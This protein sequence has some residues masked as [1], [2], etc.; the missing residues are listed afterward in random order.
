MS[1]ARDARDRVT[2]CMKRSRS[3]LEQVYA[4]AK[5]NRAYYDQHCISVSETSLFKAMEND[6]NESLVSDESQLELI[7]SI[8]KLIDVD[9]LVMQLSTAASEREPLRL[10]VES[11]RSSTSNICAV[12]NHNQLKYVHTQNSANVA[13]GA[14][15]TTAPTVESYPS[16]KDGAFGGRIL[17]QSSK[18]MVEKCTNV[19]FVLTVMFSTS[20]SDHTQPRIEFTIACPSKDHSDG[21]RGFMNDLRVEV[22]PQQSYATRIEP[23]VLKLSIEVQYSIYSKLRVLIEQTRESQICK[24]LTYASDASNQFDPPPMECMPCDYGVQDGY[25]AYMNTTQRRRFQ[26]PWVISAAVSRFANALRI[27]VIIDAARLA[28]MNVIDRPEHFTQWKAAPID[29]CVFEHDHT[30]KSSKGIVRHL[31]LVA[32]FHPHFSR[33]ICGLYHNMNEAHASM[34]IA[35]KDSHVFKLVIS[36]CGATIG[37]GQAQCNRKKSHHSCEAGNA[38]TCYE[39]ICVKL[40]CFHS[41]DNTSKTSH[42]ILL[43][44]AEYDFAKLLLHH[45]KRLKTLCDELDGSDSEFQALNR[46]QR[47]IERELRH[48][49]S[50]IDRSILNGCTPEMDLTISVALANHSALHT[51][52]LLSNTSKSSSASSASSASASSSST[53]A[54]LQSSSVDGSI[55]S[56]SADART[57]YSRLN[58]YRGSQQPCNVLLY[59]NKKPANVSMAYVYGRIVPAKTRK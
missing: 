1:D 15:V 55:V 35:N 17:L 50:L 42:Q 2:S 25:G 47:E 10:Q 6:G 46:V 24:L 19:N 49:E 41:G 16:S 28:D 36:A 33:C 38:R 54:A 59:L 20:S 39:A 18:A 31:Q 27:P 14:N 11:A 12:F 29:T 56:A 23:I 26:V 30:D 52:R 40:Q 5:S 21:V 34:S 7:Q 48:K 45:S 43:S 32:T 53:P 13:N 4:N 58:W 44:D 57:S 3:E 9:E 37:H 51:N 22:Y 8:L